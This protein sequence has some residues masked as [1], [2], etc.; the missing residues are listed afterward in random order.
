MTFR[1]VLDLIPCGIQDPLPSPA[2]WAV[3]RRRMSGELQ[4]IRRI[5]KEAKR[6]G[7]NTG[8]ARGLK[9]GR[10]EGLQGVADALT[11]KISNEIQREK[12][13]QEQI[14]DAALS[15][16]EKIIGEASRSKPEILRANINRIKPLVIESTYR[17]LVINPSEMKFIDSLHKELPW[18]TKIEV[19]ESISPGCAKLLIPDGEFSIDAIEQL[20]YLGESIRKKLANEQ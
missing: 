20:K 12:I 18:L 13:L 6:V 3:W 17:I 4:R 9:I 7:F 15:L 16:A 14:L 10:D 1:K 19:C 2:I 5:R 11:L 8:H